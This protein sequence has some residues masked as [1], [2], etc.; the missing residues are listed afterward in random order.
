MSYRFLG[1]ALVLMLVIQ[2]INI[3]F[4]A[5]SYNPTY[6]YK[7]VS[8]G[9]RMR[10]AKSQFETVKNNAKRLLQD[11]ELARIEAEKQAKLAEEK[12]LKEIEE[13]KRLEEER[14]AK[15]KAKAAEEA[16]AKAEAEKAAKE[17]KVNPTKPTPPTSNI[18]GSKQDWMRAAGIPESD[19]Q[20]VD[21]IVTR[22]STWNPSA[23][24]R[25]S[26]ACGLAQALPC[27]KTGCANYADPICSLRWQYGY[28]KARYGSY[29]GAYSF[30]VK[31]HWY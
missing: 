16:K 2:V 24:N 27:A 8:K 9:E 30:W 19:W 15:A 25:S 7:F 6:E 21:Y 10:I 11:K 1:F 4:T 28:V 17:A 5:N 13:K 26:G 29:A 20:Y 22:E 18:T 12:R 3:G 23:V 14:A 31:N